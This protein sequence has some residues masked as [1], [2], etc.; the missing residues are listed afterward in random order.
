MSIDLMKQ[1]ATVSLTKHMEKS[2]AD[3]NDPG[4]IEMEAEMYI[5]TST[6]MDGRY[7]HK[8]HQDSEMQ[9]TVTRDLGLALTGLDK[10]QNIPVFA[11]DRSVRDIGVA[12]EDNYTHLLDNWLKNNNLVPY[13]NFMP[14]IQNVMKNFHGQKGDF[15]D[16]PPKL[17]IVHTDGVPADMVTFKT[18]II[19]AAQYP[20]FWIFIGHGQSLEFLRDLDTMGGRVV[21]NVALVELDDARNLSDEQYYDKLTEELITSWY[22][23]IRKEGITKK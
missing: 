15:H 4:D 1:A 7:R 17:V 2:L 6:S 11:F 5:D 21:D 12:T 19:D 8:H 20:I 23:A 9:V 18:A 13:T 3:G 16:Q 22:P 10:D 14:I